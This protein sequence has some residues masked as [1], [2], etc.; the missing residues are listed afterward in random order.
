MAPVRTRNLALMGLF[1]A[2]SA[3]GAAVKVPSPT[4][5]VAFDSAPGFLAA[6]L[7]GPGYGALAAALGHLFSSLFAGFPLTVPIHLFIALEMAA[8]AAAYGALKKY[9]LPV[10]TVVTAALN[11]VVGPVLL[12]PL[13]HF[14]LPFF[15]A[16]LAPLLVTSAANVLTAAVLYK[17][18][19]L[20]LPAH[21][22]GQSQ[23]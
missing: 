17:S 21:R 8:F 13:P 5:T 6:L 19:A 10:A 15:F 23:V 18:L 14:G 3:A 16:M 2:L 20:V 22:R 4:G 9:N 7:L 12:I 1:I 11:G